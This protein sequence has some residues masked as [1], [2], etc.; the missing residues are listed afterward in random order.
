[1]SKGITIDAKN[2]VLKNEVI[3][4]AAGHGITIH[5]GASA[6][7]IN[8]KVIECSG[9]GVQVDAGHLG[10]A[11][12]GGEF[13]H[14][15][16]DGISGETGQWYIYG[17]YIHDNGGQVDSRDGIQATDPD[18][19]EIYGCRIENHYNAGII[20]K[21]GR[22]GGHIYS[23]MC[24]GRRHGIAM[25]GAYSHK[26]DVRRNWL[27]GFENGC[28]GYGQKPRGN[29]NWLKES[30]NFFEKCQNNV[31]LEWDK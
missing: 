15:G 3:S 9:R 17:S 24:M 1:M 6:T 22:R 20:I 8:C 26:S 30:D 21:P 5:A 4:G 19:F 16:N 10:I 25:E 11:I 18:W 31:L 14:N 23:N 12:I 13:A 28:Y 7:L 29:P 27:V 2:V